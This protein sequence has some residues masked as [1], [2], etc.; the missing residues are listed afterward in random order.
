MSPR[1]TGA[2][3]ARRLAIAAFVAAIPFVVSAGTPVGA[4]PLLNRSTTVTSSNPVVAEN[5]Q[6]GTSAWRIGQGGYR[7]ADD[8]NAQIK[9]YASS[10]SVDKGESITFKVSV[11][12]AQTYGIDVYRMGCYPDSSGTCLGGRLMTS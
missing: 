7:T 2:G 11:N 6:P 1:S 4:A 9:G 3:A 10:T 12:P 5:A 8:A